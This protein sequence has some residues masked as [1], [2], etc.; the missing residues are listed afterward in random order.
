MLDSTVR[1]V[2]DEG[3][4]PIQYA[5]LLATLR[6]A[7][8]V[9][10]LV[11]LLKREG[12]RR[13]MP[14]DERNAYLAVYRRLLPMS[15]V[16][17]A[18]GPLTQ[19]KLVVYDLSEYDDVSKVVAVN[20]VLR[21]ALEQGYMTVIIDEIHRLAKKTERGEHVMP[22][23]MEAVRESRA[24]GIRLIVADQHLAK[25][26]VSIVDQLAN[27][28][29]RYPKPPHG[30][31]PEIAE[32]LPKLGPGEA[33]L[34]YVSIYAITLDW[35]KIK[36]AA[37]HVIKRREQE[38]SIRAIA[39]NVTTEELEAY[40]R[41]DADEETVKKLRKLGLVRGSKRLTSLG[42]K[43]YQQLLNE[44]VRRKTAL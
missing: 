39:K 22:V 19:G 2:F 38:E 33:L 18:E 8:T 42:K 11:E 35:P 23:L 14:Q 21:K 37:K 10:E 36:P 44:K 34:Q 29:L 31:R 5:S 9:D 32:R 27:I 25:V 16:K 30:V 13:D 3:L 17:W 4:T 43:V 15:L 6:K 41:G 28:Y 7:R 12:S 20:L 40:I 24:L 1:L 26:P